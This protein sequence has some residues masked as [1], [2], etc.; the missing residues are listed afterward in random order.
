MGL[1]HISLVTLIFVATS[2]SIVLAQATNQVMI[3]STS[4]YVDSL[5]YFHVFGTIENNSPSVIKFVQVL[6]V[7]YDTNNNIVGTGFTYGEPHTIAPGGNASFDLPLAEE[8]NI[9]PG[10]IQ[11]YTLALNYQ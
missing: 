11:N 7:F 1:F 8:I 9:S 5:N 4:N 3:S 6:G 10:K 2:S